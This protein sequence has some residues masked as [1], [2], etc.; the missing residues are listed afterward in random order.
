VIDGERESVMN[1][2]SLT[3]VLF[4]FVVSLPFSTMAQPAG[5]MAG[6]PT[7]W[8]NH[9]ENV[10]VKRS[11]RAGA[12]VPKLVYEGRGRTTRTIGTGFGSAATT[13]CPGGFASSSII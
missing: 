7:D 11:P 3:L 12:Q 5:Q 6:R 4:L 10:R 2:R 1:I 13:G 9:P 8:P